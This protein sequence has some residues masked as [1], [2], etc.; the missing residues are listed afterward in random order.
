MKSNFAC[1][2]ESGRAKSTTQTQAAQ[3]AQDSNSLT[4]V[5]AAQPKRAQCKS[6]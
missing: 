2:H 1:P 4:T 5:V 6:M 3:A